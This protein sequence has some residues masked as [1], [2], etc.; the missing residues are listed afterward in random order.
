[1]ADWDENLGFDQRMRSVAK[2]GRASLSIAIEPSLL[3]VFQQV[4]WLCPA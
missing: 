2:A 1:M 4:W 3:K